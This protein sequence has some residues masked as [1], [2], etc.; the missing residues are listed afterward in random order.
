MLKSLLRHGVHRPTAEKLVSGYP[1]ET[2]EHHVQVLD[3]ILKRPGVK[4]PRSA[5][6]YLVQSIR[7]G[8]DTPIGFQSPSTQRPSRCQRREMAASSRET[9]RQRLIAEHIKKL[10][11][12]ERQQLEHAALTIRQQAD[13]R[14][15]S[16]VPRDARRAVAREPL[17]TPH[18]GR[19]MSDVCCQSSSHIPDEYAKLFPEDRHTRIL[20]A[21]H[22]PSAWRRRN[23]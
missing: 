11:G 8:Y 1:P 22:R 23:V 13:A 20:F 5:A 15:T 7:E 18:P 19:N 3:W 16:T 4:T 10:S 12:A 9:Q 21:L 17:P 2:I 6:G 14:S